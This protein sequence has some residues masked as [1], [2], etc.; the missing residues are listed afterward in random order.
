MTG[1]AP[2]LVLP[3]QVSR[4]TQD[5]CDICLFMALKLK[6]TSNIFCSL[7]KSLTVLAYLRASRL[8]PA[9]WE[10]LD[11]HLYFHPSTLP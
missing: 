5:F 11:G 8:L 7:L 6:G 10:Q 4:T 9:E 2:E 3:F 1:T